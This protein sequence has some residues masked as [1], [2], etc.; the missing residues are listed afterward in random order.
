MLV[1]EQVQG[2]DRLWLSRS[3]RLDSEKRGASRLIQLATV[4]WR[5]VMFELAP[6]W[7]E[8]YEGLNR[9]SR[10]RV[11]RLAPS[12]L[13]L[14][15][16]ML[17]SGRLGA[18]E[19]PFPTEHTVD[20]D[21]NSAHSVYAADVDG[22]GDLD[23]LGAAVVADDIAWWENT[24]GD[25][26]AWT[27]HPV[28]GDFDGAHSVYAAD[29]DGDGDLDV[30]GAAERCRR[31]RVVGEHGRGRHGLDRAPRRR[32]LRRRFFRLCRRCG[33]RRRPRCA[34]RGG[35]CRRH[36]VV[37]EH[38][39]GRHGL[40]R[41][42]RRR[43]LRLRSF[44]LCRRRG[45]RRRPRCARRGGLNADDIAW[46][47]NTAGDGTAWTE[48]P[49][50]GDFDGAFSV[51][52]ADVDG[53]GDLDVLGA[54]GLAG[55]I[56]W[57]ENTAG[58]GTAW[59]EHPV[60]VDFNAA[61][62]VFAADVDGDGDLDVLGAALNAD[63]IAWWENETIHRNAV[64]PTENA[65]DGAFDGAASVSAADVDGDGDLDVLGAALNADDIT[66]WENTAGDGTAWTAHTVDGA[67]DNAA[68]VYA[69]DVD[70][71]GDLDVLGAAVL[72]DDIAWWENT[73]GDGT[74]WTVHTVD[75]AFDGARSVF[76]ADVDGDGDLD[77]LGAATA[78]DDIAWWEN[79]AGDGTAWTEHTVDGD[80]DGAWSV[81][82][83]DVDGD[84]DLDVLGAAAVADDIAWWENTAGDG[85]AWTEHTVDGAFDF[86]RSVYAADVDGD[87]DLDVLGAAVFAN[88]IAWWEN[89]NMDGDG[90]TWM[91]HPVD[92]DFDFARFRLCRRRGRRRRPRCA[93]RGAEC[94]RHRVVGE[95]GR[96]RHG[97]DRAHRRRGLRIRF[98]RSLPPM[99]T[100]MATSM[101]S[102]RRAMPT[103]LR[104]GRTAAGS[105]GCPRLPSR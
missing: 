70:G 46:W 35:T 85:T 78:A 13:P 53:D 57:W 89:T 47:E 94:R 39:R 48:H 79:T 60:D 75:G 90:T 10:W 5:P 31:H 58:D 28:D 51:Y 100:A 38:G 66:W 55:D 76:A 33:R 4:E 54:A 30:L 68:S 9:P 96:E 65:V 102:A 32:G 18:G 15:L 17:G 104:G 93:R 83:A 71:D 29:V 3:D 16:L 59:T 62:S 44:R 49:V 50:D 52:A 25:G 40:D 105:S 21:F 101:C 8:K 56:A 43:G 37:G 7:F 81:Y 88:D 6:P 61:R 19:V 69:A 73:A 92:V 2:D 98:F 45:R 97:L 26:T 36:R 12:F 77:V 11:R 80:F 103:T 34:R 27:E 99:W 74:A 23:V 14:V 20:G 84:G 87:G 41:A 63:D 42:P 91:E 22:D 72:A 67:F 1:G 64:Y 95:H 82:A 24:A 86:A